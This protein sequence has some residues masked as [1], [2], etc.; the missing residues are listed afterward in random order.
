MRNLKVLL[1]AVGLVFSGAQSAVAHAELVKSFPVANSTLTKVPKYVQLE[2]GE[3]ITNLKSKNANSIVIL[4]SKAI[5][6]AT[7][8]IVIK[9]AIA[10]VEFVGTLKPG[11]YTVKYRIVSADGHVLNSQFKFTLS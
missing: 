7:S 1:I 11:K 5:K 2:F 9:K 4:D 10:R 8:K 6:I 3:A